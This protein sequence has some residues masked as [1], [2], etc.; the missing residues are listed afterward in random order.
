M[1][2]E[3]EELLDSIV[4]DL[5]NNSIEIRELIQKDWE[6]SK[7]IAELETYVETG[8]YI[9]RKLRKQN[10][11]YR[12]VIQKAYDELPQGYTNK[13]IRVL[14]EALEGDCIHCNGKGFNGLDYCPQCN[15]MEEDDDN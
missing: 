9:N 8:S 2:K 5:L 1:D 7:R 10:K 13:A 4:G 6:K 3:H 15:Q 12:E 11:R 14:G